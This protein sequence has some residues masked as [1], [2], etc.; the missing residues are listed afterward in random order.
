MAARC[1]FRSSC[2]VDGEGGLYIAD[3]PSIIG[4]A[5]L[6]PQ[7]DSECNAGPGSMERAMIVAEGRPIGPEDLALPGGDKS[8]V[9]QSN[10]EGR[11]PTLAENEREYLLQVLEETGWVISGQRERP[12]CLGC[13]DRR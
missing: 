13:R 12:S 10:D 11:R 4:A 3:L 6:Q 8:R 9:H 5:G 1:V 2:R 7:A